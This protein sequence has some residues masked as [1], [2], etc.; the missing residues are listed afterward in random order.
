MK[1]VLPSLVSDKEAAFVKGR[2]LVHNVLICHDQLRHYNRKTSP[3]R[4][5][6]IDLRKAYDMVSWEFVTEALEVYG[7]HS[8][9]IQ[10]VMVCMSS[11]KLTVRINTEGHGYFEG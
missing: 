6:K 4:M 7:F 8:S 10:M 5:M 11:T 2:S 3:R 9:F 1:D